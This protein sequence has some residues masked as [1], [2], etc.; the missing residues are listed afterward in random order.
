MS[1]AYTMI[2]GVGTK[3]SSN[4]MSWKRINGHKKHALAI[5]T[6]VETKNGMKLYVYKYTRDC[7]NYPTYTLSFKPTDLTLSSHRILAGYTEDGLTKL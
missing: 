5:D 1:M 2:G 4:V 3:T 6:L 7:D